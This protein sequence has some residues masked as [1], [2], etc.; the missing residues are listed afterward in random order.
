[1]IGIA[2]LHFCAPAIDKLSNTLCADTE[3]VGPNPNLPGNDSGYCAAKDFA[4]ASPDALH[5]VLQHQSTAQSRDVP[6]LEL[7]QLHDFET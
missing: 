1:L 3:E 5:E 4:D 2:Y 6:L 7:A